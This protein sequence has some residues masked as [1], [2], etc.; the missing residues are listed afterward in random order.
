MKVMKREDPSFDSAAKFIQPKKAVYGYQRE[1]TKLKASNLKA[2]QVQG[3]KAKTLRFG[4]FSE[5]DSE[6]ER[7]NHMSDSE[8]EEENDETMKKLAQVIKST[9]KMQK[10]QINLCS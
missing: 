1:R 6:E 3:M 5:S 4:E 7:P 8:D 2:G 9:K 10:V